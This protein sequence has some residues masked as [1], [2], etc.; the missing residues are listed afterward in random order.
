M[1]NLFSA[2]LASLISTFLIIRYEYLHGHL[3]GD[4]D[5]LAPQKFHHKV[6]PRVG[7]IGIAL[8]L[9]IALSVHQTLNQEHNSPLEII[10]CATPAFLIGVLEDFTKKV[11]IQLR[12]LATALS[13]VAGAFFLNAT[14]T[15]INVAGIDEIL[16]LPI[17]S[18][19]FTVFAVSGLTNA[20]NIIDG[21]NGLASMVGVITLSALAYISFLNSDIHLMYLSLLMLVSILGF[22]IWNYPKG[23]IFL[24]DGG[25][26]LIGFWVATISI[27]LVT[28]HH[29]IS[30]WFALLVNAY[31]VVETAFTIYRRKIHQ[32]KNPG[33]ADGIHFHSL[34][35]RRLI[36][37]NSKKT[38][39]FLNNN[40]RTSP[41][42][43]LLSSLSIIPAVYFRESTTKLLLCFC[44]FS[45][46]YIWIYK[47]I[48]NFQLPNWLKNL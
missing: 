27:L 16:S 32:N 25:A 42:L 6:V 5:F 2:F 17:F 19:I 37:S 1:S 33:Q 3:T 44:F 23:L 31:P 43:W 24:G 20:Y 14:I 26:Y 12:L 35:Y 36:V 45:I 41:F 29:N 46:F 38:F 4:H 30:P 48:I 22:F 18:L 13:A 47:K 40:S 39:K 11:G 34:L 7:G 21:F 15:Q 10:L 28:R 8:G 9:I